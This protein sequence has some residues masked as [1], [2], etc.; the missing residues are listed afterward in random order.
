MH[1]AFSVSSKHHRSR[2]PSPTYTSAT[3]KPPWPTSTLSTQHYEGTTTGSAKRSGVRSS[4]TV[5]KPVQGQKPT[6]GGAGPRNMSSPLVWTTT[7][8]VHLTLGSF[9]LI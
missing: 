5:A 9:I 2:P 3:A 8:A 1:L 4:N 6:A 7:L